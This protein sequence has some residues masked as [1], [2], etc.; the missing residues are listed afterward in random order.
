MRARSLFPT[1][2][3]L[4]LASSSFAQVGPFPVE[5]FEFA[6]ADDYQTG[7]PQGDAHIIWDDDRKSFVL[8]PEGDGSYVENSAGFSGISETAITVAA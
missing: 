8:N 7:T 1:F 6:D 4:L 2:L 3:V 5:H